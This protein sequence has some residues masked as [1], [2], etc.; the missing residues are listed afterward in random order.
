[1]N[2]NAR[3][4]FKFARAIALLAIVLAPLNA[5]TVPGQNAKSASSNTPASQQLSAAADEKAEKI[6]ESAIK[7]LGGNSYLNIRSA[8]GRGYYTVFKD[9]VS[10]L[11]ASFVDY[12]V[13]PDKERTEFRGGGTLIIQ[14][15]NGDHSWL[16]DG[17]TKAV[18]NMTPAQVEDFKLGMRSSMEN[19]LHGWWRKEGAKLAY[20]G[21]REAG[22]GLRNEALRLT[23]ADGFAV[24]FEFGA[25]DG[26]PAKVIYKKK[27]A[28]GAE[29]LEEDRLAQY[30]NVNGINAPFVIDHY[31]A[32]VQAS[33]T[34]FQSIEYN[35]PVSE[36]LFARPTNLKA[37]K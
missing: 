20:A 31:R 34:N 28:E 15:N 12:I 33:R 4:N 16:F 17:A 8:V 9:G 18:K 35:R 13:Y 37:L 23:Y 6:I 19:L 25:R 32:G 2:R 27:N 22:I 7:V 10:G 1:M 29:I 24:E 30:V 3:L 5:F 21:R 26:L 14:T 11:P 36:A